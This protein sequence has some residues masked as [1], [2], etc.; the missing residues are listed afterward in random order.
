MLI[1]MGFG[2]KWTSWVMNLVRAGFIA[3]RINDNNSPYFRPTK[4]HRQGDP[5]SPVLFNL[6]ADV[7]TRLLIK[8]A[9]K[10]YIVGVMNDLYS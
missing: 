3:I 4:G 10:G 5:S 1:F 9:N 2:L 8:A 7:F 6:V